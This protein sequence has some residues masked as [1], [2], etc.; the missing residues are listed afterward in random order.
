MCDPTFEQHLQE[1]VGKLWQSVT[2][3]HW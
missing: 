3:L 2:S 1:L